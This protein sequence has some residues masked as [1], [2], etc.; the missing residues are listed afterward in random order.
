[1]FICVFTAHS[2]ELERTALKP[3]KQSISALLSLC[4]PRFLLKERHPVFSGNRP[5]I[6]REARVAGKALND[7]FKV[8][9][10]VRFQTGLWASLPR[11]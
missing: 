5:G 4:L 1:M 11:A 7:C 8:R 3:L 10:C 9:F 2:A 6:Q